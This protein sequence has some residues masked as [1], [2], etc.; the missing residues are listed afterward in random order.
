M[1]KSQCGLNKQQKGFKEEKK[2][3]RLHIEG[4]TLEGSWQKGLSL[5]CGD[6]RD[7]PLGKGNGIS[8]RQEN[9][10]HAQ[11]TSLWLEVGGGGRRSGWKNSLRI[12][13]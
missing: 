3:E 1:V 12:F 8:S 6:G 10:V 13:Y 2:Q 11:K 7:R 4:G 9:I 5:T